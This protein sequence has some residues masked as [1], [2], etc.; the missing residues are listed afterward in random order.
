MYK[1]ESVLVQYNYTYQVGLYKFLL[2][3]V[4]FVCDMKSV[5]KWIRADG[6]RFNQQS[7]LV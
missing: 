2:T 1:A 5:A 3:G 6:Y 4:R 7:L